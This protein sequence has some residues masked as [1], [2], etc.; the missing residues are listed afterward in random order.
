MKSSDSIRAVSSSLKRFL[1][2]LCATLGAAAAG[3]VACRL[4]PGHKD[5]AHVDA[6]PWLTADFYRV[7][8]D[9][10]Y[11]I[12][13]RANGEIN[14]LGMRGP[15]R[16][17]QKPP[18]VYRVLVLG[19]SVA[20]GI[21]VRPTET[22][23]AQLEQMLYAR[24]RLQ[25][26][27][28]NAGVPGYNTEQELR[29]L[30]RVGLALEPDAVVLAYCPN[31]VLVTPIVF[32]SGDD[33]VYYRPGSGASRY[34]PWLVRHSALFRRVLA[35]VEQRRGE[36]EHVDVESNRAALGAIARELAQRGL[37][38]VTVIYPFLEGEF[39]AYR[40]RH[41]QVHAMVHEIL[42]PL[43]VDVIDLLEA[44]RGRDYREF[45]NRYDPEDSC[46]PNDDGH[47][48]A[49][50]RVADW[51]LARPAFQPAPKAGG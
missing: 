49:A 29:W 24:G 25:V 18:G 41:A 16:A 5:D 17:K 6:T 20:Y 31:D 9:L 34:A 40:R 32:R 44:W 30:E 11:E 28:L 4:L 2:V 46:H 33:M 43:G 26:E 8:D 15:E 42:K 21:G 39:S 37:P 1:L 45:R 22:L 12:I 13:P 27:V 47:R 38:L 50:R 48:D 3:E 19:D 23:S 51:L 7:V 36:A 14:S 10:A 35:F